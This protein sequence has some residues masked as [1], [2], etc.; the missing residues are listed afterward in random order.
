LLPRTDALDLFGSRRAAELH[1][2]PHCRGAGK[3]VKIV[4]QVFRESKQEEDQ[5]AGSVDAPRTYYFNVAGM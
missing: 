3:S 5:E 4:T 1:K 2:S